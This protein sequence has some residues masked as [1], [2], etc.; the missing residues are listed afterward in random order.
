MPRGNGPFKVLEKVNN[1]A[2]K[3]ELL[4]DIGVSPT[5]NI[6][7]LTS[8]LRDED[9]GDDLRQITI[10][11]GRMTQ[12]SCL[13]QSKRALKSFLVLKSFVTRDLIHALI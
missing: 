9:D 10:K 6:G 3:L 5:F 4:A 8:Y 12:I 1:N 11:K 13:L 2:Y 7:D